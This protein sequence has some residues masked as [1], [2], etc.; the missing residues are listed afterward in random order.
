MRAASERFAGL[1]RGVNIPSGVRISSGD[2]ISKAKDFPS[3]VRFIQYVGDTDNLILEVSHD[4]ATESFLRQVLRQYLDVDSVVLSSVVLS[5]VFGEAK[6]F[7]TLHGYSTGH[8][9]R[10]VRNSQEWEIGVVLWSENLPDSMGGTGLFRSGKNAVALRV[11][12]ACGL[13]VEKRCQTEGGKRSRITWGNTVIMPWK[14]AL[15]R[16]GVWAE[17]QCLTSRALGTIER[18]VQRLNS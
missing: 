6:T 1:L 16:S 7:L 9:Y 13:L 18:M 12:G 8:P 17:N 10:V 3:E 11:I 15:M 5:R 14:R 4:A 2:L